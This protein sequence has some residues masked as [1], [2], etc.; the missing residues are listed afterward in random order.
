MSAANAKAQVARLLKLVPYLYAH[1]ENG[2]GVS[3]D[4]AARALGVSNRQ[5]LADLKVLWMCGLPGGMPDDL[6]DVDLDA[7]EGEDADG[8]IR[9]S[10]ADYLSRPLRLRPTEAAALI[11]ALR[12]LRDSSPEATRE[13]VDRVVVKL[14]RA[15]A[16]GAAD[17]VG[18]ADTEP[19]NAPD[20]DPVLLQQ[21][22]DRGVQVKLV[23]YV[24][25]RD[26]ESTRVVDPHRLVSQDGAT[27]LD[28][29]C[30]AAQ[31]KR[32]FRLDRIREAHHLDTPV[33]T[34]PEAVELAESIFEIGSGQVATLLLDPAARW[35][36]E[37][38]P[39]L[40]ARE[41]GDGA[42]EVDLAY[43]DTRWMLRLL[44]RLA[45]YARVV[46]PPDLAEALQRSATAALAGY[47]RGVDS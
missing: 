20:I 23:Y 12:A 45:P 5:V 37:Y 39:V 18:L 15:A 21:A 19:E 46:Q 7:L 8:V 29:W 16:T 22:V 33:A 47:G 25:S 35:V 10:N 11:V 2:D 44:L 41:A 32:L 42:L 40:D 26:E 9:I 30:H 17:Q 36:P 27:Y 6:I 43:A 24:P 38:Y 4:A 13:I 14:E 28:A 1:G 3:I 31:S 34:E